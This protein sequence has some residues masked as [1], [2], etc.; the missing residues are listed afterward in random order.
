L[1]NR[2][3][4]AD[5]PIL[6]TDRP[7]RPERPVIGGNRPGFGNDNNINIGN[8]VNVGNRF[9]NRPVNRPNW[10]VDP[11]YSRPGWGMND[12]WHNQWHDHCINH[13][14]H[15]YNGCWHGYW[16][17]SWYAPIYSGAIGWGLGTWTSGW[18]DTSVYYNPYYV[19]VA[20]QAMPYDYS[21]P[22]VVNNY[23][24]ADAA[25][26]DVPPV[27]S[28]AAAE[29]GLADF[30]AGLAKFKVGDYAGALKALDSALK[31]LPGDPVIHEV[32]CLALF[33]TG[34][35]DAAAA[36]LNSFLSSAPGM[37]WTTMSGL[38]GRIEDY[39][40]QLRSLERYCRSNASDPAAHFVL[41]YH[42]LVTG[43][44]DD[45]I[46]ALQ[47]VVKA[48]PKDVTAKKMLNALVPS[49]EAAKA[50][51][52]TLAPS[53]AQT[54]LVGTWTTQAGEANI[55]LAITEESQFTWTARTK[56]SPDVKLSGKISSS[57]DGILLESAEQGAMAGSVTSQGPDA[58]QF[59]ISGAPASDPGL[60]FKR[61][62]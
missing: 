16:G 22:I 15:W 52:P 23:V 56:G 37:D 48:Q 25:G 24:S 38:Y 40:T 20:V 9:E 60:S 44:K 8:D 62:E 51:A 33:A 34:D 54:D 39:S 10:D 28:D 45:A 7:H 5:R 55:E 19:P 29:K 57:A 26:G 46:Q 53:D 30:D 3:G 1:P 17:S 35:Y 41:A 27:Q 12:N 32:R 58:W 61:I 36:G 13:H 18:G 11:G 59:A 31:Q 42:Y 14:H 47:A 4:N 2:P 50:P 6:G 49:A 43:S 21:Q